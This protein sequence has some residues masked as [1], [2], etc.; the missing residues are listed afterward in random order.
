MVVTIVL[1]V[2]SGDLKIKSFTIFFNSKLIIIIYEPHRVGKRLSSEKT[3][4][5]NEESL[6]DLVLIVIEV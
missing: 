1:R 3:V 5:Y 2:I 6:K 4:E